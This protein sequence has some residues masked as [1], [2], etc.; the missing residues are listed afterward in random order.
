MGK[1]IFITGTDTDVGKTYITGL[2]GR[3]LLARDKNVITMKPLQTGSSGISEDI[4]T[5][6]KIM[7]IDLHRFDLD[8]ITN[9]YNFPFPAS[10]H[11]SARI[12]KV[13][14]DIKKIK[15]NIS[16]LSKNFDYV[17]IEGAGGLIVPIT[18][19]YTIVD[20]ISDLRLPVI[21]VTTPKIGTL[22]HTFLSLE[23]LKNRK[24]DVLSVIYNNYTNKED[25]ITLDNIMTMK[26]FYPEIPFI[27][28]KDI[29]RVVDIIEKD[30]RLLFQF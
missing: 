4:I 2:I 21:V 12:S 29:E 28:T 13:E 22:N 14:I 5:H 25:E 3:S 7:G 23:F 1:L 15:N 9:P 27:E 19:K 24:V 30:N 11:L 18:G 16:H 8:G 17:I 10:P 20:L 26:Y 6:R